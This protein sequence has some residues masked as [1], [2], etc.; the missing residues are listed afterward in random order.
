MTASCLSTN[1]PIQ[2]YL[3]KT[4]WTRNQVLKHRTR[5][6]ADGTPVELQLWSITRDAWA[7][8]KR[9]NPALLRKMENGEFYEDSRSK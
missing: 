2:N 1:K 9:S 6:N 3:T 5:T 8:W 4:G 7:D